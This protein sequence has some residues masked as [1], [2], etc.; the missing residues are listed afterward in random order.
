[1]QSDMNLESGEFIDLDSLQARCLGNLQIV[2]RVLGKFRT[3]LDIELG[4]LEAAI[5]S[6]DVTTFCAVAHRLKGMSA[7][8][9]AWPLHDCAKESASW[10]TEELDEL[11]TICN[12]FTKARTH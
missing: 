4:A 9:E 10:L 2:E 12:A 3:Q 7:N 8:V 6:H 1:M 5:V 11:S